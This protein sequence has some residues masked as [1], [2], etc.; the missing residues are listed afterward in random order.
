MWVSSSRL[1]SSRGASCPRVAAWWP[2][3]RPRWASRRRRPAR[4]QASGTSRSRSRS[5][6]PPRASRACSRSASSV[7]LPSSGR[8]QRASCWV[9]H[10]CAASP[11]TS[12]R[13]LCRSAPCRRSAL[14]RS[15]ALCSSWRWSALSS[16]RARSRGGLAR[17]SPSRMPGSSCPLHSVARRPCGCTRAWACRGPTL[18]PLPC[19]AARRSL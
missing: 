2:L 3:E 1:R 6:W 11:L 19:F 5:W 14:W 18:R 15:S 8:S 4:A 13:R 12:P 17:P 16:T 10:S 9:R 7:S